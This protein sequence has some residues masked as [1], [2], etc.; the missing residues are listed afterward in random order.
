[1]SSSSPVGGGLISRPIKL[2]DAGEAVRV[3][4]KETANKFGIALAFSQPI[5]QMEYVLA[6][7][8]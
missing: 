7:K 4:P 5:A 1:L 2:T 3:E 8:D 6:A